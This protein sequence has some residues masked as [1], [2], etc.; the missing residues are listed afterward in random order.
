MT[1]TKTIIE[2]LGDF[3]HAVE[4][5]TLPDRVRHESKRL[6]L[7]SLACAVEAV[8]DPTTKIGTD[9]AVTFG[10]GAD[11]A[12][13]VGRSGRVSEVAASFANAELVNAYDHDA[14]MPPGHVTPYVL[15][16]ILAAAEA[17]GRPLSV[18]VAGVA[19]AHEITYRLGKASDYLRDMKDGEVVPPRVS[20]Y[21]MSIFGGAAGVGLTKQ[22]SKEKLIEA[23]GLAGPLSPVNT[24]RTWM[25]HAPT[26]TLKY[27]PAGPLAQAISTAAALAEG[28]HKGDRQMLD[29]AEFGY[30]AVIGTQRWE[31]AAI[32][33][34]LGEHW[35]SVDELSF[36]PYPHCRVMHSLFQSLQDIVWDNDIAPDEIESIKAY[37]ETFVF[38]PV[39]FDP[40]LSTVRDAQFRIPHGLA[41]A[42]HGIQA[43][44]QWQDQETVFSPSVLGLM[45]KT[46]YAAHPAYSEALA[47][48]PAARMSKV[49]VRARGEE[50]SRERRFPKGS[51]SPDPDT[52]MTDEQLIEKL[53]VNAERFMSDSAVD[54]AA[55][56]ILGEDS[57]GGI[58]E[59]MSLFRD[60]SAV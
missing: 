50:W 12:S 44:P 57:A 18:V 60:S 11:A 2:A 34:G 42:A 56:L 35:R 36:K 17:G 4:Y 45:E 5:R 46:E 8:D 23:L 19:L 15:P 30:P 43:G 49:V 40:D 25:M 39:W 37:G 47:E 9:F 53:R 13:M 16:P 3:A 31:P 21:S 10:G 14:V 26:T 28:G 6:L 29:D 48:N 51:P 55:E 33:D 1:D 27:Q 38:Q 59:L 58:D 7:D 22:F 54:R 41:L 32:T 20:G 24:H 52:Y